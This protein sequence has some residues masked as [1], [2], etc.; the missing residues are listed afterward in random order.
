MRKANKV[1][2]MKAA[3]QEQ[4]E[5]TKRDLAWDQMLNSVQHVGK[6][7]YVWVPMDLLYVDESI[8]RIDDYSKAKVQQLAMEWDDNLCDPIQVLFILKKRNVQSSMVCIDTWLLV[9][10]E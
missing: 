5:V 6:E 10:K 2:E 9:S 3:G 8:Q 7:K 4:M 1:T